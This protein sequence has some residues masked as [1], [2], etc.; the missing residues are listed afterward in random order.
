MSP[1]PSIPFS[2]A[3]ALS[4]SARWTLAARLG[5]AACLVGPLVVAFLV[6]HHN[7]HGDAA[8]QSVRSPVIA[9]DLSWSVSFDKSKQIE[10]T[11]RDLADSGRR[12]GLVLFSDTAYEALPVGT[13]SDALRPFLRFFKGGTANP[14]QATFSAGTRISAALDLARRMLKQ[15]HE[16]K[17]SV[18]LISDLDD[19]PR[20]EVELA[21]TLVTYQREAIPIRMIAVDPV[22]QDEQFFRDA[23][24]SVGTVSRA[25][26]G[27]PTGGGHGFPTLL[28]V[29]VGLVALALALNEHAL[30][31]LTWGRRR[32]T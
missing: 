13:P 28:V 32:T 8:L 27:T 24:R 21:R 4:H 18:V 31:A 3:A 2:S 6:T 29:L 17:G 7:R 30:G 20:D 22:P 9:L 10:R 15:T 5:L 14:W 1:R 12:I 23:L 19:S 11:L 26:S 16:T 25:T